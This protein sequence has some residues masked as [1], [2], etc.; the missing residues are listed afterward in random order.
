VIQR[1]D[2]ILSAAGA[3]NEQST[4]PFTTLYM[5][6]TSKM[7]DNRWPAD[8]GSSWMMLVKYHQGTIEAKTIVPWG[9]SPDPD[10]PHYAD[11]APLFANRQYKKALLTRDEIV[12][13]AE[14]TITLE[15]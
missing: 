15:Y 11:Q 2:Q 4:A 10:S 8:R 3:G 5:T 12:A 13:D 6:G 14:S 7:V 1:G 9:N